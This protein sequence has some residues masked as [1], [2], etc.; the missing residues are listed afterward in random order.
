[1]S[2]EYEGGQRKLYVQRL[3]ALKQGSGRMVRTG[4]MVGHRRW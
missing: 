3:G 4:P 2:A 1:M